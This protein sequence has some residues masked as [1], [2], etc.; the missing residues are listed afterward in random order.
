MYGGDMEDHNRVTTVP[1]WSRCTCV[2]VQGKDLV[3]ALDL[4][5]RY[6]L[7]DRRA[8][9]QIRFLNLKTNQDL[10]G[11]VKAW[12]PLF[13]GDTWLR[14]KVAWAR[15]PLAQFWAFQS[16]LTAEMD[17]ILSFKTGEKERLKTALLKYIA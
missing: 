15:S 8:E 16:K 6:N 3:Y 2:E 9:R 10:V 14:E 5:D 7:L 17:L 12:G 1:T 13:I 11:F 4:E